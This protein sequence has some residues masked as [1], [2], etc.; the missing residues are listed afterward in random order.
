MTKPE[1]PSHDL[2][3]IMATQIQ[4]MR[5]GPETLGSWLTMQFGGG[6]AGRKRAIA[7]C[8]AVAL[9]SIHT[10]KNHADPDADVVKQ[11]I[12]AVVNWKKS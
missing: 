7:L 5:F 9:T 4:Q 6:K 8:H 11:I 3:E 1:E 2:V 10:L 12:E